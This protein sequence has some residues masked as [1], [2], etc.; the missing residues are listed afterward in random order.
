MNA[1][2]RARRAIK[3]PEPEPLHEFSSTQV[4]LSGRP[5]EIIRKMQHSIQPADIGSEGLEEYPHVTIKYGLHFQ[6]PSV[7]LR[8]ALKTFGPVTVTLGKTSL[9]KN[10]DADVLK[11]DVDSPDLHRL[12]KLISRL[13]PTFDTFPKYV[14]HLTIGYLR[15]GRGAKYAADK[16]LEGQKLTFDSIVFS[17]KKGHRETLPLGHVMPGPYRVR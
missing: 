2:Y 6:T 8:Q 3:D 5:V 17:G 12:N 4:Q 1:T 16:S 15:P 7:K 14:P 11:V 10:G 9:F 13:V